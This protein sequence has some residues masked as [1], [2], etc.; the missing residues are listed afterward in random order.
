MRKQEKQLLMMGAFLCLSAAMYLGVTL[1]DQIRKPA[2]VISEE[3]TERIFT[4]DPADI[5]ML[6]WKAGGES[7]E[8]S[9]QDGIWTVNQDISIPVRQSSIT[10]MIGEAAAIKPVRTI[11]AG[12]PAEYGLEEASYVL[13]AEDA[14]GIREQIRIGNTSSLGEEVYIQTDASEDIYLVRT[15]LPS[16]MPSDMLSLVKQETLPSMLSPVKMT[17]RKKDA[18]PYVLIAPEDP[19]KYTYTDYY[20]WFEIAGE[21]YRPLDRG[22]AEKLVNSVKNLRWESCADYSADLTEYGLEDPEITAVVSD[23][24]TD[25][26]VLFGD[27]AGEGFRYACLPDSHMVYTVKED[28]YAGLAG[29]S[30]DS[31]RPEDICHMDWLSVTGLDLVYGET[32]HRIVIETLAGN[33][34]INYRYTEN[35]AELDEDGVSDIKAMIDKMIPAR[36]LEEEDPAGILDRQPVLRITFHRNSDNYETM[37]LAFFRYSDMYDLVQFNGEARQLISTHAAQAV[38]GLAERLKAAN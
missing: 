4:P 37:D 15:K 35:G 33:A 16:L 30:Y 20:K 22:K 10:D 11:S 26:T 18:E 38:I 12:D 13:E 34:G 7:F 31:L 19:E 17:V 29:A 21:E 23:E 32:E 6:K 3:K 24:S 36:Q 2:S 5:V 14:S 27:E 9:R 25:I 8:A 28:V 1:S